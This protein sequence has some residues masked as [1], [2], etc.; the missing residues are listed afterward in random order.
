MEKRR[1]GNT[2]MDVT[3]LGFG[4][5]EIGYEY[6]APDMVEK[7]LNDAL[8][9]GLNLIDTAECYADSEEMIGNSLKHR[10]KDFYL[11]T[12][13]GHGKT[14]MEAAWE[15][16]K[17]R[18]SIDRSLTRLKTDY[19]DLIQLHSCSRDILQNGGV[20]EVLQEAKKAGKARYIGYS[21]DGQDAV[22]AIKTGAFD[23]LQ[24]SVSIADQEAID[25]TL[26]LARE[27]NMGVIAKRPIANAAWR[28]KTKPDND[29]IV[30]YWQRLNK[31]N[32]EFI[33]G[34]TTKIVEMALRF[35][36]SVSGVHTMIVGTTKLGRW[37]ENAQLVARGSLSAGEFEAIRAV[38]KR[39]STA[40]WVGQV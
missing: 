15:P 11:F 37:R 21:G 35:T 18:Q 17:I 9:A 36:L 28:S 39:A 34:D 19:V 16:E 3:V 14:Y 29:Y 4:G 13:C 20:I 8:D 24:T 6:V 26:P 22:Y 27:N 10:R 23:T 5:G 40:E 7:I 33:N 31:L 38:W 32:Y 25:L 12:K 1:L 30:E 2:D